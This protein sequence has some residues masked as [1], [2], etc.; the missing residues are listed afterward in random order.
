MSISFFSEK[1]PAEKFVEHL[2]QLDWKKEEKD[3]EDQEVTEE[4]PKT[5]EDYKWHKVRRKVEENLG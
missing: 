1:T 3:L 4:K 5:F 2:R